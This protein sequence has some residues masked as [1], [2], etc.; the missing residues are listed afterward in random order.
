MITLLA[1]LLL[2]GQPQT[3]YVENAAREALQHSIEH[4]DIGIVIRLG[5][6]DRT[7]GRSG[8]EIAEQIEKAIKAE[9]T[10]TGVSFIQLVPIPETEIRFVSRGNFF[11]DPT[12]RKTS[13]H[14]EEIA[15]ENDGGFYTRLAR[16]SMTTMQ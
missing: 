1:A 11:A 6:Q 5:Q 7:A 4:D 14:I 13:F 9:G 8:Q 2:L 15:A 3:G 16:W 12:S 10:T